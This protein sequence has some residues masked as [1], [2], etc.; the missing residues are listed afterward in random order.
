MKKTKFFTF[1]LAAVLLFSALGGPVSASF[2]QSAPGTYSGAVILVDRQTGRVLHQKNQNVK[3]YPASLTKMMTVLLAVEAVENGSVSLSD[4]VT[5]SANITYDLSSLGSTAGIAVGE[6]MSLESL[7]YCAMLSSAN[8]A[9]NIIAEHV[10]GT[11]SEFIAH[12][13]RRASELGCT[14]TSFFNTHGLTSSSHYTTAADLAKIALEASR[15]TMFMD[16]CGTTER[17]IPATNYSGERTLHNSNALICADSQYGSQW[18]YEGANGIKTGHTS[19]AGYCLASTA[20]RN[21]VQLLCVTLSAETSNGCFAD[22]KALYDWAFANYVPEERPALSLLSGPEEGIVENSIPD[23]AGPALD[24]AAGVVFNR[25]TGE[26][27]FAKNAGARI[28]PADTVKLMTALLAVEAIENSQLSLSTETAVSPMAGYDLGT[29]SNRLLQEGEVLTLE[30][31]LYLALL[32]SADDAC[33]VIA[34]LV[35]GS[36]GEFIAAMNERAARLGCIG[37]HFN[38]THGLF[39]ANTYSTAADMARIGMEA[40]RHE[41]LA[42]MCAVVSVDLP[43]TNLS[44]TR[45]LYTT[46]ALLNDASIYGGGYVYPRASGLKTGS[47]S[48]AGYCLVSTAEDEEAGIHL[49]CAVFGGTG[50]NGYSNFSDTIRLYNYIFENY[51]Y[52]EV[53]SPNVNIASVDVNLGK[54]VDYVNLRPAGSVT[55]LLPKDYDPNQFQLDLQVYSLQQGKIVTA[56]VTAGEVLGEVSVLRDGQNFGTVKLVAAASVDLSRTQYIR[57]S[58][59]ETTRSGSFRLIS[60]LLILIV[61][62]YLVMVG[63]YRFKRI[64]YRRAV[65]AQQSTPD[66]AWEPHEKQPEIAAEAYEEPKAPRE[67]SRGGR[68]AMEDWEAGEDAW[69]AAETAEDRGTGKR[70]EEAEA[71]PTERYHPE[72][73]GE[74]EAVLS[75]ASG[76]GRHGKSSSRQ[77]GTSDSTGNPSRERRS[78]HSLTI[79][80]QYN[81]PFSD[82]D[83]LDSGEDKDYFDDFFNNKKK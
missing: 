21:G 44:G 80:R 30:D 78:R 79:D 68:D 39:D 20:E 24:S 65:A 32:P 38:N 15:H 45:K 2:A 50:T 31:L 56:P 3:V 77:N 36:V 27:F 70:W 82:I 25:D 11:I 17:V 76:A 26:I 49:A 63:F 58:I 22:H 16:F 67:E 47:N 8:E 83:L 9:C 28:Y 55:L 6:T 29:S 60:G 73:D 57:S 66:L 52:Q 81:D 33:N 23:T 12:M 10:D 71:F 34:E 62:F 43:D 13:N 42:R 1:F 41:I 69:E 5:A 61:L 59:E 46:N 51:S 14:G 72:Q 54:E 64:Q 18:V 4:Q 40:A 74:A 75:G 48:G 19:Y 7:I 35:S 53:L 37:T